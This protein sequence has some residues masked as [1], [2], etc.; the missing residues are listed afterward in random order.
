MTLEELN[1]SEEPDLIPVFVPM[2]GAVLQATEDKKGSPLTI[3]EVHEI[4]DKSACIMMEE[5]D[6]EAMASTRGVDLDP[7]NCWY[8]WQM[9]R[10]ELGR[11]PDLDPGGR[12]NFVRPSDS[13]YQATIDEAQATLGP[14]KKIF[15]RDWQ[16]S[17]SIKTRIAGS[18]GTAFMWL[19][20]IESTAT[21][22]VAEL[23]ELVE[24]INDLEVGQSFEVPD[25]EVMDWMVNDDGVL[26]GGFSLRLHRSKLTES[27]QL[28]FDQHIGVHTYA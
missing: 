25:E 1:M 19:T 21:G 3:E 15:D 24:A 22:F 11:K 6:A 28:A 2:L 23:F 18:Q 12:V 8:D 17:C 10:R 26:F 9:L 7:E 20:V 5:A 4:R 14:L 16:A 27:E 13:E